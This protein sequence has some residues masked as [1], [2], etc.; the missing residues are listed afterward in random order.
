M[1]HVWG[2]GIPY[3]VILYVCTL[4]LIILYVWACRDDARVVFIKVSML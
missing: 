1:L 3:Y 4:N 2:L